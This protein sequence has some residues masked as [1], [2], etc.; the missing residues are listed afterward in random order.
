MRLSKAWVCALPIILACSVSAAEREPR[1]TYEVVRGWPKLP[2]GHSLGQA[3]GVDVSRAVVNGK[4][5]RLVQRDRRGV[6][7]EHLRVGAA[8]AA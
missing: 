8:R 5:H 7:G 2:E 4:A 6:V 1:V 3:T